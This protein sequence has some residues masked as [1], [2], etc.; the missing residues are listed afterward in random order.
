MKA[1][2]ISDADSRSLLDQ[3]ELEALKRDHWGQQPDRPVTVADMHRTF[4]YVVTRW[5][6]EMG[7]DTV[8]R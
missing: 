4:H 7:A 8:H 2:I 1:I 6:Q 3:L 5:L